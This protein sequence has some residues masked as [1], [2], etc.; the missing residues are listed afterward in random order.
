MVSDARITVDIN[1]AD[2]LRQL[3]GIEGQANLAISGGLNDSAFG[4]RRFWQ[5]DINTFVDRPTNFTRKVFVKKSSPSNLIALT[6]LPRIQAEYLTPLVE[7][8]LRRPGDYG[9]LSDDILVPVN[10]RLNK[11][12]NFPL[13]PKRWLGRL[14]ERIRGGFV[15]SPQGG[16]EGRGAVYQRLA[17][18]RL[19]LLAVF[20]QTVDYDKTLPLEE[21]TE[22]FAPEA[23]KLMQQNLDRVLS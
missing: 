17:R 12:G 8:G 10:A 11:F 23:D 6:F 19:K 16:D 15:G 9:T 20:R 7:G 21:T 5:A 18:G 3:R 1:V 14:E 2:I 22:T 4:L 13:G